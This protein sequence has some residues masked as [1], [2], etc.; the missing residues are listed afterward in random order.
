LDYR[1]QSN[2]PTLDEELHQYYRYH[3]KE[4]S[5]YN[6]FLG[7]FIINNVMHFRYLYRDHEVAIPSGEISDKSYP[8][9]EIVNDF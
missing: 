7:K 3:Q 2:G 8:F 9:K 5:D 1:H 6:E 4:A